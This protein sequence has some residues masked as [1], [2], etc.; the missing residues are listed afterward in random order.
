LRQRTRDGG[1]IRVA[2]RWEL[3]QD[4]AGNPVAVVE[5]NLA[6]LIPSSCMFEVI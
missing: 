5:A 6:R 2:S 3:Q 1:R 4:Q